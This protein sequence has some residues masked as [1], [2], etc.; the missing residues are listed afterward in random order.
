MA[1]NSNG[2]SVFEF[3]TI[4]D[5]IKQNVNGVKDEDVN[6]CL[7]ILDALKSGKINYE[8]EIDIL[9]IADVDVDD[10]GDI[11]PSVLSVDVCPKEVLDFILWNLPKN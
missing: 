11:V 9:N 2:L 6:L 4:G 5:F 8:D 10:V 1:K 3:N 7:N